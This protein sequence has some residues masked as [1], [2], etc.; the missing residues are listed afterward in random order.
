MRPTRFRAGA[1]QSFAAEGL[2]AH[3]RADHAAVHVGVADLS[4]RDDL[5]DEA[6]DAAMDAEREAETRTAQPFEHG[7]ELAAPV[8]A[9][10]KDRAEH[11]GARQV[12]QREL[13]RDR[14]DEIAPG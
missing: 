9:D 5:V 7:A 10:V 13:E 6:L 14:A 12:L 1:R 3:H 4:G 2:Y 11:L 8:G